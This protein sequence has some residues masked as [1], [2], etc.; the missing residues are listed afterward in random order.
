MSKFKTGE[1]IVKLAFG[2]GRKIKDLKV[3]PYQTMTRA[4]FDNLDK[5]LG[6]LAAAQSMGGLKLTKAQQNYFRNQVKQLDL[7]RERVLN[8]SPEKDAV[9]RAYEEVMEKVRTGAPLN[10]SDKAKLEAAGFKPDESKDLFK[11]FE[12]KV[13]ENKTPFTDMVQ[14][15]IGDVKLYGDETFDEIEFIRK[16]KRHPRDEKAKGGIIAAVKKL[17]KKYGKGTIKK[18]KDMKRPKK[19]IEKEE[20][21]QLFKSFKEK[22]G[23]AGGGIARKLVTEGIK[24]ALK[25]TKKGYDAPG[26]DFQAL[27]DNPSYLMS[28]VNMQKIKK[29]EL[30]RK[31]LVRDLLRKKGGGKFTRGPQPKA[32][33]ADLKL[34]DEYIAKLKNKIS[35]EGYYGEGAAAEKAL[36]E[37]RPDLPFSKFVKDKS[38]HASGGLAHMLGYAD[39]DRVPAAGGGL[40]MKLLKAMGENN[41]AQAYRKYLASVKRRSQEGDIKSFAPELG[42]GA[43]GGILANRALTRKIKEI[44][45]QERDAFYDRLASEYKE[46]YRDDPEMLRIMLEGLEKR[47]QEKPVRGMYSEGGMSRR[48]FLKIMGAIAAF[49][50]VGKFFKGA[51]IATKV[52]PMVTQTKDMPAHF[53]KLVEKI[54]KEGKIVSA[55]KS[56]FIKKYQHPTRKDIEMEVQ[57]DGEQISVTFET[58]QGAPG[59]Y[60]YRKGDIIEEGKF[61]GQREGAEFKEA[62]ELGKMNPDGDVDTDINEFI[63][64]GTENLDKFVGMPK[65]STSKS[66]IILQDP[67]YS[68]GGVAG[69]LGE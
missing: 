49:P 33:E 17:N 61:A 57:G 35:K 43:G 32:T 50:V 68:K 66:K 53:P 19:A 48:T 59:Y 36:I 22:H 39:G 60:E 16:N 26:A 52:P 20:L 44:S 6:R 34:L 46:K 3:I 54:L 24:S 37:K 5:F 45:Q 31:Q 58:D 47:R 29:L 51:K 28:P 62:E 14:I 25:R 11:G 56:G 10:P 18:A 55:E 65:Q 13:I 15:E 8:F 41:P 7:Y 38:K 63:D 27:M 67:E 23:F 9:V 69:L 12:P 40:L 21:E 2:M 1:G 30:Y 64:T 42:A 4:Q